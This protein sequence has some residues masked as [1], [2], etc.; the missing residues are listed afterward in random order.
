MTTRRLARTLL[1]IGMST[2]INTA[3][4]LVLIVAGVSWWPLATAAA[5]AWHAGWLVLFALVYWR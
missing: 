3:L 5:V 4:A 2:A 1:V